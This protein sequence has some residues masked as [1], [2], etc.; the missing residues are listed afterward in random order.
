MNRRRRGLS[1]AIIS[2]II[3]IILAALFMAVLRQFDGDIVE[4]FEW[5]FNWIADLINRVADK[6]SEMP[7][8]RNIFT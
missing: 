8:F 4:A 3:F 5:I 7:G 6:F 1:G 2:L